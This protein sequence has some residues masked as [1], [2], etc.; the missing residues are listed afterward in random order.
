MLPRL[1]RRDSDAFRILYESMAGS[2]ASFA[3]GLVRDRGAAEDVVQ[4][5]FLELAEAVAD[6]AGDGD[7]LRAWMYRCVRFRCLDEIRRRQRRP[8][9]PSD[10]LPDHEPAPFRDP[11]D[12]MMD[13]VLEAALASLTEQQ[14]TVIILRH[15][16]GLSGEEVARVVGSNRTAVYALAARAEA[17]LRRRLGAVESNGSTASEPVKAEPGGPHR[18]TKGRQPKS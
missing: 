5:A 18:S 6:L 17:M 7:S 15:V 8:E 3:Y 11:V 13:P 12:E 2:L 9:S 10:Q 1:R 16:V 14:R 4:Q